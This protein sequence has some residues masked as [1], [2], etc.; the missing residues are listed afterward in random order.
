[1][2]ATRRSVAVLALA[3]ALAVPGV[4]AGATLNA[5]LSGRKEVPKAG[6][7][8]GTA[9]LTLNPKRGRVC[10]SMTLHHVG[11]AQMGHIHQ[12]GRGVAGPIVVAL[13]T[14]PTKR[15][16]GCVSAPKS[17]IRAIIKHP[18]RFYVN[19]HTVKFPAGAARGQLHR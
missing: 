9:R 12:G 19:V 15:P 1:M 11:T 4:A 14:T 2:V 16:H 5:T 10:F 3:G 18:S 8:S 6:N 17:Q 13:F 7:G